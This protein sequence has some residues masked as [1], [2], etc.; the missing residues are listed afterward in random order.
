MC[1]VAEQF[2]DDVIRSKVMGI[3]LGSMALGVLL[4]YPFGSLLYDFVGKM[5]PFLIISIAVFLNG[6]MF[7]V[8]CLLVY[9]QD[10]LKCINYTKIEL[11]LNIGIIL[12]TFIIEQ[13][14][15]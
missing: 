12:Q 9:L 2:P 14:T 4:G 6:G 8:I 5:A 3:V 13:Q 1:L 7:L 11:G 10:T 15:V